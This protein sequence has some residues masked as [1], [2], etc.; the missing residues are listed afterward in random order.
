MTAPSGK[1]GVAFQQVLLI[2]DPH[3]CHYLQ[4]SDHRSAQACPHLPGLIQQFREEH[5]QLGLQ[6]RIVDLQQEFRVAPLPHQIP[7]AFVHGDARRGHTGGH[8]GDDSM[9]SGR[10][11]QVTPPQDAHQLVHVE[12]VGDEA[13]NASQAMTDPFTTDS[14]QRLHPDQYREHPVVLSEGPNAAAPGIDIA[15]KG[16]PDLAVVVVKVNGTV[17]TGLVQPQQGAGGELG[18]GRPHRPPEG[19]DGTKSQ[20]RRPSIPTGPF[21]LTFPVF[22]PVGFEGPGRIGSQLRRHSQGAQDA[23]G[24]LVA[25]DHQ[26]IGTVTP[27]HGLQVAVHDTGFRSKSHRKLVLGGSHS[28]A[29]DHHGAQSVGEFALE[30]RALAGHH[31]VVAADLAKE[32]GRKDIRQLDLTHRIEITAGPLQVVRQ[33]AQFQ[34]GVAQNAANLTDHL[35]DA[36]VGPGIAIPVVTGKQQAQR[37]ARSPGLPRSQHPSQLGELNQATDPEL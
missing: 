8:A 15:L 28:Q 6:I 22:R 23:L 13:G 21:Q 3:S 10:K 1:F 4:V 32:E 37:G 33:D 18:Q 12:L 35:L 7:Q 19:V 26:R 11:E 14:I 31:P 27:A 34:V 16:G 36:D 25:G 20:N 9:K 30:H 2:I 24:F 17:V 5:L 29:A